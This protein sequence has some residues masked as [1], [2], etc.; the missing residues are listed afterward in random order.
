MGDLGE[1]YLNTWL[2]Q[3]STWSTYFKQNPTAT[4]VRV[5]PGEIYHSRLAGQV[6]FASEPRE[7]VCS[8]PRATDFGIT[9]CCPCLGICVSVVCAWKS[10]KKCELRKRMLALKGCLRKPSAQKLVIVSKSYSIFPFSITTK[11]T[12]WL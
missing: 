1:P 5:F 11:F 12:I 6:S 3:A 2:G 7:V 4:L 9:D 10:T 8:F